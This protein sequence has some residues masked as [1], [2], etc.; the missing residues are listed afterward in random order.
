MSRELTLLVSRTCTLPWRSASS[1]VSGTGPLLRW[2][3]NEIDREIIVPDRIG[4]PDRGRIRGGGGRTGKRQHRSKGH[5]I[6]NG[7]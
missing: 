1:S 7:G 3:V 5:A 2:A 6:Q 4:H